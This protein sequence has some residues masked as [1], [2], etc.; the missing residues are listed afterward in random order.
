M[1]GLG[2]PEKAV[3]GISLVELEVEP[4][5]FRLENDEMENSGTGKA[6]HVR[7]WGAFSGRLLAE[8]SQA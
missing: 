5:G 3:S 4:S 8:T 6:W 2:W 7:A 1:S